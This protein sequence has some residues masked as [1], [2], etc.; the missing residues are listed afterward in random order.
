MCG[1]VG[2]VSREKE[3]DLI[4]KLTRSLSHRGPDES[5]YSIIQIDNYFI[6]FGSTRLS[7]VGQDLGKMPMSDNERNH[8]IYNGELYDLERIK[9]QIDNKIST[10]S[11]T[12]HLFE[13]LKKFKHNKLNQLNGMFAFGFFDSTEKSILLARD[14]LGIKPLYFMQTKEFPLIFSSEIKPLLSFKFSNGE[15]RENEIENYLMFGGINKFS[16]LVS[17]IHSVQPGGYLKWNLEK[18]IESEYFVPEK[19]YEENNL[20]LE[21]LL[22][23]VI[24]DQLKAD[25]NVDLLLSGGID[26]TIITYI[27]KKI[28][29]KNVKAY[30]LSFS[31]KKF[32]EARKASLISKELGIEHEI[33]NFNVENNDQIIDELINILPE[34]IG[35][36]SI[37]PTYF[38]NKFVSKETK[39]VLSGDGADELFAGYDWYRS[40]MASPYLPKGTENLFYFYSKFFNQFSDSANIDLNSKFKLFF[41][42]QNSN[43]E[44][45][46]LHWQNTFKLFDTN[47]QEEIF[48]SYIKKLNL[49]S[50]KNKYDLTQLIDLNTYIY[51]NILKKS[52][53]ASML[54]G[55]EVRPV[56]LDDR[57]LN[58]SLSKSQ[59]ENISLLKSKK[60]LRKLVSKF[61]AFSNQKKQGFSHDFSGWIENVGLPYLES[62]K[63][64]FQL[65]N[66]YL[67]SNKNIKKASTIEDRNVWKMYSLFKWI[68]VNKLDV[69]K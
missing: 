45:K 38:L 9:N 52:D 32:D 58:Y 18:T 16:N 2:F 57:V 59:K 44:V 30:S 37:V 41:S 48:N 34:P 36:P 63:N 15:I 8:L 40:L 67:K 64:D 21:D 5:D 65:I 12:Y 19:N 11:D 53:T 50:A 26:S 1:L 42:G 49:S 25:V 69:V 56:Y 17:D 24:D 61:S 51:T 62:H 13:F 20:N 46:V 14:K 66:S 47:Y 27:T 10:S 28:L 6:H 60:E 23:T 54:N 33:I 29:N 22:A 68:E 3:E 39:A 31:N 7:I 4:S 35:D 43:K 55:L